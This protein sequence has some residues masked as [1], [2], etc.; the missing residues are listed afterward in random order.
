MWHRINCFSKSMYMY[1]TDYFNVELKSFSF[2]NKAL[3]KGQKWGVS[4]VL[5][6]H[7]SM[8]SPTRGMIK[9]M[10]FHNFIKNYV[11]A[12]QWFVHFYGIYD[13]Y[14]YVSVT[15]SHGKPTM[16][17]SSSAISA[18]ILWRI[19]QRKWL[20]SSLKQRPWMQKVGHTRVNES[21]YDNRIL[22]Q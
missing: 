20:C 4:V 18:S 14:W 21:L 5:V 7:F 22:P 1:I 8:L 9:V 17:C 6:S 13:C 16:L 11:A 12:I 3:S 19:S 15:S 2:S 10:N